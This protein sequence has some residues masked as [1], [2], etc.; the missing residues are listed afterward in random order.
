[1]SRH[2]TRYIKQVRKAG[3]DKITVMAIGGI[4]AFQGCKEKVIDGSIVVLVKLGPNLGKHAQLVLQGPVYW[5]GKRL[6]LD[7][8]RTR[9]NRTISPVFSLFEYTDRKKTGPVGPVMTGFYRTDT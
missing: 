4:S 9:K 7:Q 2:P 5:T 3:E 8:T 6:E 1:L